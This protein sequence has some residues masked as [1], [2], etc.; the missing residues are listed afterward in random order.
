MSNSG[1]HARIDQ[2]GI[3]PLPV[4]ISRL[5]GQ[6]ARGI[7]CPERFGKSFPDLR[8]KTVHG[9]KFFLRHIFK[10]GI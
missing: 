1:F 8:R 2:N 5:P 7:A 4:Q 3:Q 9:I 10:T 6:R